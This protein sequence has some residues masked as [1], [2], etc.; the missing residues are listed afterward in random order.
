[1][2]KKKKKQ[3]TNIYNIYVN[4]DVSKAATPSQAKKNVIDKIK[5]FLGIGT[6]AADIFDKVKH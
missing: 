4:N 1:M 5:N 6:I 2:G 3:V